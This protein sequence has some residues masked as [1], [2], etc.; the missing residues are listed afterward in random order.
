MLQFSVRDCTGLDKMPNGQEG[1]QRLLLRESPN[2]GLPPC[3]FSVLSSPSR[4]S[5]SKFLM[6]ELALSEWAHLP[7]AN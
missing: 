6:N 7:I 2:L 3:S 4:G 1:G 5:D